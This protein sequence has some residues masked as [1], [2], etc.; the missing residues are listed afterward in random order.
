MQRI[1][2]VFLHLASFAILTVFTQVGGLL[3]L[4]SV[5]LSI[6]FKKKKRYVFPVVYLIFN[7]F[8]IPPIA[9]QF[10]RKKLP[11]FEKQLQPK[12]IFYPLLFRNYVDENLEMVLKASS[13][14]LIKKD[15]RITYLDANF[16][17]FDGFPLLPHRSHDDGKKIDI[18]FMYMDGN[19]KSTN[20]K[21]SISG[22]G[23]YVDANNHTASNCL[24]KGYWQ[25]DFPKYLTLGT[26]N[27]LKFDETK[28]KS[29]IKEFLSHSQTEKIFIEPYLK[30]R[31]HLKNGKIR[32]HGCKAVRHDDHIHLQVK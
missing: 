3:W 1:R 21:P 6:K 10:G 16:P 14:E 9:N 27:S 26:I 23:A 20:K 18:N 4:F 30:E 7:A 29:T 28:T 22:Y 17:F 5:W 13:L 24:K 12:N 32:F 15:I 2:I 11:V 31:L 8:L 25:Y 19:G